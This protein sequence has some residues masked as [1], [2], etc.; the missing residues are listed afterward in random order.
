MKGGEK[1]AR[2]K[3]K[4]SEAC[5]L[6]ITKCLQQGRQHLRLRRELRLE[7]RPRVLQRPE[8]KLHLPE[9]LFR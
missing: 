6:P 5:D 2:T 9:K 7:Q 1:D 4:I 8:Q 3:L